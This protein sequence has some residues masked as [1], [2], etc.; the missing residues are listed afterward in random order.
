MTKRIGWMVLVCLALVLSGTPAS[1][2]E[3]SGDVI[4]FHA[5][6]LTVPFAEMEKAFEAA[7]PKVDILREGGGHRGI[8]GKMPGG[9]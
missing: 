4:I 5:G 1:S 7:N 3:L 2:A 8:A 6:S 9:L